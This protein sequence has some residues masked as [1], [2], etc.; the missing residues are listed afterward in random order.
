M[1]LLVN[2]KADLNAKQWSV[3]CPTSYIPPLVLLMARVCRA[4]CTPVMMAARQHRVATMQLL[5]DLKAD[6]DVQDK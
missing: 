6:L 3:A 1:R 5:A 2:M 4:G